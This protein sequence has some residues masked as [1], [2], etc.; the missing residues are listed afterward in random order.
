MYDA[1]VELKNREVI[2]ITKHSNSEVAYSL[3]LMCQ[4]TI[5]WDVFIL[6]EYRYPEDY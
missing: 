1:C 4:W 5:S 6:L 2:E 3:L